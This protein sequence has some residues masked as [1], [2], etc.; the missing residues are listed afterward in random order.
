M[1]EYMYFAGVSTKIDVGIEPVFGVIFQRSMAGLVLA[2]LYN[3]FIMS[4]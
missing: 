1:L 2:G 4:I 3:S